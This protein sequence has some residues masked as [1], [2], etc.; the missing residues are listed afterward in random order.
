MTR[1][2]FLQGIHNFS[3]RE[4]FLK[5][6]SEATGL[7][8]DHFPMHY[9]LNDMK[10]H[11]ELIGKAN[12]LIEGSDDRFIVLGHSFGGELAY[13][14]SDAA[15]Q[16]ID[17][18]VTFASPHKLS[19]ARRRGLPFRENVPVASRDSY[20]FYFD[21]VVPFFLTKHPTARAH[22]NVVGTHTRVPDRAAFFRKLVLGDAS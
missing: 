10:K 2:L 5:E 21:P 11:R 20:G 22:K 18:I 14:L 4:G 7:P 16:K 12:A 8:V 13:C 9:G 1:I 15:Y 6:V 19:F 17:R 3:L